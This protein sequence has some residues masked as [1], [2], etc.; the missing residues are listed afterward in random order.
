MYVSSFRHQVKSYH[1]TN[2]HYLTMTVSDAMS[3]YLL[4]ILN[5]LKIKK[6]LKICL[7]L[8]SNRKEKTNRISSF[9]EID[10]IKR[11]LKNFIVEKKILMI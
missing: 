3:S 8:A 10:F 6:K 4:T 7:A 1:D 5:N 2:Q 9:H 11:D